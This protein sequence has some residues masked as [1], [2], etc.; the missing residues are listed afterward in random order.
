MTKLIALV[1]ALLLAVACGGAATSTPEPAPT[2]TPVP[3]PEP[4]ATPR[5]TP[6]PE[7]SPTPAPTATPQPPA[8]EA[9]RLADL[10]DP[11]LI[12]I[13]QKMES[14]EPVWTVYFHSDDW[15]T[16]GRNTLINDVFELVKLEN[17]AT[18]DGYQ[19]I[20][21]ET[22]VALEPDII[23]AE[24]IESIVG[25]PDL[26]GLHMAQ[27]PDHIPH[28]IFVLGEGLSFSFD[29]PRFHESRRGIGR[30][31]LPRG[32]PG[33]RGRGGGGTHP[34]GRGDTLALAVDRIY[35][36]PA[37]CQHNLELHETTGRMGGSRYNSGGLTLDGAATRIASVPGTGI[38]CGAGPAG[39][40][41]RERGW[42]LWPSYIWA[43][44]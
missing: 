3:T 27:D 10:G 7:P 12:D 9:D 30:F 13:G 5:P 1:A 28:H 31:F 8:E 6:T 20:S 44:T 17:I 16:P 19:E 34:R 14:V 39:P 24:S 41:R 32:L 26:S 38:R 29:N 21:P 18:H 37:R 36:K 35:G 23:V 4:T 11:R 40:G 2:A 15:R 43:A 25:N 42:S 33:P 22:I